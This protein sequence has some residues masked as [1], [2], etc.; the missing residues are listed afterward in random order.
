MNKKTLH[1]LNCSL[2]TQKTLPAHVPYCSIDLLHPPL[3]VPQ[4]PVPAS[5]LLH[6]INES[7]SL[8]FRR[9]SQPISSGTN[10]TAKAMARTQLTSPNPAG[11]PS[12]EEVQSR[13]PQC[14][15]RAEKV[16][17]A[18]N[19]KLGAIRTLRLWGLHVCVLSLSSSPFFPSPL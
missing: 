12:T 17:E 6:S 14:H 18:A 5:T 3:H 4:S 11:G 15:Q 16:V 8:Y 1:L 2:L 13:T 9:S 19:S 7:N 10:A